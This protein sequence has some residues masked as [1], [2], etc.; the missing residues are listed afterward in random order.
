MSNVRAEEP[1]VLAQNGQSA[2]R[3]LVPEDASWFHSRFDALAGA[4]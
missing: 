1:L 2:W 3:I 4:G